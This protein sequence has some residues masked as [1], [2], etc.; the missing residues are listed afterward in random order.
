MLAM[1]FATIGFG[2]AVGNS[3]DNKL[4]IAGTFGLEDFRSFRANGF[5]GFAVDLGFGVV[6]EKNGR[7]GVDSKYWLLI[8]FRF[9]RAVNEMQENTF[10]LL[11]SMKYGGYITQK[12]A[13]IFVT[14]V[15]RS[16]GLTINHV[17]C[18]R[19]VMEEFVNHNKSTHLIFGDISQ[20]RKTKISPPTWNFFFA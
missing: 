3:N 5:V 18:T 4:S 1:R 19:K 12:F 8:S 6:M 11:K 13:T 9:L 2:Y 17:H 15:V 10:R 7:A 20:E 14:I 16:E